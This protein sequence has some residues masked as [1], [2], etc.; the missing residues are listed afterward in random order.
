MPKQTTYLNAEKTDFVIL[1]W[2]FNW[3][4]LTVTYKGNNIGVI[5]NSKELKKGQ[6]FSLD[7]KR[8]IS[9]KL[10]GSLFP[11]LEILLNG[12]YVKG[13]ATDPRTQ[14]KQV[15][16][17]ALV[18]GLF[19]IVI[20]AV[21]SLGKINLFLNLG[22]GIGTIVTG[23]IIVLLALGI[24]KGFLW[25]LYGFWI[26]LVLDVIFSV[27][28]AAEANVSPVSGVAIKVFLMVYVY[29]G[30]KAVKTL[31]VERAEMASE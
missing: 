27:V 25:T 29:K 17:A 19:N 18:F 5:P 3:K 4:N 31:K 8:T 13:S 30:V 20:G 24:R 7:D 10:K 2:G 16:F 21:V 11:D 12:S 23:A 6:T 15:Y 22:V 14:I 28:Y 1:S 26:L 9:V